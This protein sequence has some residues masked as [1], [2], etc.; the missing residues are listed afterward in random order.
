MCGDNF[1]IVFLKI[2]SFLFTLEMQ[3]NTSVIC[4]NLV[5]FKKKFDVDVNGCLKIMNR[6]QQY[7]VFKHHEHKST[8]HHTITIHTK[9]S[10]T[11]T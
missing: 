8:K 1:F 4:F 10:K 2:I 5:Y 6:A 7:F 3:W 11:Q 9:T